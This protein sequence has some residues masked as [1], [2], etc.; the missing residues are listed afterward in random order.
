MGSLLKATS[1]ALLSFS[2]HRNAACGE[3]V[4]I[5]L[6]AGGEKQT[7]D[8]LFLGGPRQGLSLLGADTTFLPAPFLFFLG[9]T[10]ITAFPPP[11]RCLTK[12]SSGASSVKPQQLISIAW[13]FQEDAAGLWWSNLWKFKGWFQAGHLEGSLQQ[14]SLGQWAQFLP[15]TIGFCKTTS[16]RGL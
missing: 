9:F 16:L 6:R 8:E 7:P 3:A 12:G 5:Q 2:T 15:I 10:S 14:P 11:C 4:G 1:L 13:G